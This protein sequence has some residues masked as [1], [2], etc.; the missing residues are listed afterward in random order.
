MVN[1]SRP[2]TRGFTVA[3]LEEAQPEADLPDAGALQKNAT[4]IRGKS[5]ETSSRAQGVEETAV[6]PP[7]SNMMRRGSKS[8]PA[9][10]MGSPKAVRKNPYFTGIFTSQSNNNGNTEHQRWV[11]KRIPEREL[12]LNCG[13]LHFLLPVAGSWAVCWAFKGK[14]RPHNP[15]RQTS[16]R[17]VNT[18][19]WSTRRMDRQQEEQRQDR[20]R[21]RRPLHQ[22][23]GPRNPR[24]SGKWTF[25]RRPPC[26]TD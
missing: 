12:G 18:R 19:R 22:Y 25:G 26:R 11:P 5:I 15:R 2:F 1:L 14:P 10:P 21:G 8:L 9:S 13:V 23:S 17:R 16:L 7:A 6:A 20:R 24:R 3:H 4:S